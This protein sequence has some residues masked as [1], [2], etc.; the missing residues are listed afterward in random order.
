MRNSDWWR[1]DKGKIEINKVYNVEFNSSIV[2][3]NGANVVGF[4]KVADS[5]LDQGVV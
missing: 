4:I 3:H 1:G 2:P 5:M